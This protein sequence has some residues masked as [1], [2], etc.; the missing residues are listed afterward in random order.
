MA[1][2]L[3]NGCPI[4]N[5]TCKRSFQI[6]ITDP[7]YLGPPQQTNSILPQITYFST[8]VKVHWQGLKDGRTTYKYFLT[9]SVLW[10]SNFPQI[11][12]FSFPPVKLCNLESLGEL[13]PGFENKFKYLLRINS[14]GK[15]P[16]SALYNDL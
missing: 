4:P 7:L 14:R 11:C 8:Q 16:F 9:I 5:Q 13:H 2:L 12:S 15:G 3:W 6:T 1:C 10:L